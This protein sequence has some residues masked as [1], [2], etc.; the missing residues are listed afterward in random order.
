MNG[1]DETV[2][3][4]NNGVINIDNV[5]GNIV[6][7]ARAVERKENIEAEGITVYYDVIKGSLCTKEE[8]E[9]SYNEPENDFTN[10]KTGYN[11]IVKTREMQ[12]GC[13]KF[14]KYDEDDEKQMMILDHNTTASVFWHSSGKTYEGPKEVMD[15]LKIDTGEWKGTLTPENYVFNASVSYTINYNGYKARLITANE[16]AKITKNTGWD[17][18]TA[19]INDTFYYDSLTDEPSETC[20]QGNTSKC[21]YG[22][23]YDRTTTNCTTFGCLNN[24]DIG[25]SYYWTASVPSFNRTYFVQYRGYLRYGE[26]YMYV[27]LRPVI[28]VPKF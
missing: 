25:N 18:T 3:F 27:A 15:Q 2:R 22:W 5:T 6:I 12:N 21:G 10:S 8:Y 14:Y 17:E 9:S 20:T 19:T 24:A 13:L 26:T 11:G 16:I 4:Y 28:E 23:L 1:I 7:N